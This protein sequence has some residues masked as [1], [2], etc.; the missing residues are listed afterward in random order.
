MWKVNAKPYKIAVDDA[1]LTDLKSRLALTRW[2]TAP[3][4]HPWR[5]GTA[6]PYMKKVVEYW[7]DEYDWRK[8]EAALN[9]FNNYTAVVD[10]M[11]IHFIVEIGSGDNPKPLI[12]THGWPGSIVEFLDV[13]MPLA[14]PERFGGDVSDAFTVIVPSIPGFGFSGA[15]SAPITPRDVAGMWSKLM[16]E[17][18]GIDQYFAQGGDFGSIISSWLAYDFPAQ[19]IALHL[20]LVA[21]D[22]L[23]TTG[24]APDAERSWVEA[25]RVRRD[26]EAGYR[27][28]QGTKPLTLSYGLTDS[29]AGL[30]AW[31]LEKFHGWTVPGEDRPP[32]FNLDH[33]LANIMLYWL[34]G[35]GA[36]SWMYVSLIETNARR[37]PQ[38]HRVEVP[39][40]FLLCPRDVSVPPP[41]S[42]INRSYNM[43]KR[44]DAPGGGHFVALEQPVLFTHEVRSFF[45]PYRTVLE[46]RP[47]VVKL[48]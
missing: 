5:L 1:V 35:P 20:N 44:T 37:L 47:T 39:T 30:A 15:P 31:I 23:P 41:D 19:L 24:A 34:P 9:S 26:P 7:R 32:P 11:E 8:S 43:V 48:E 27:T 12:M 29:P 13:I 42:L 16:T 28:Q 18:L 22:P 2:P 4:G 14:H 25:S 21:F 3:E 33:L 38:G 17:V 36:A 45:K 46:N 10:N 40:G 6:L